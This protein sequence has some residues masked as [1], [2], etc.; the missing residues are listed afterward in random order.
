LGW[1]VNLDKDD[2]VG[3]EALRVKAELVKNNSNTKVLASFVLE[4][5]SSARHSDIII[6]GGAETGMVTSGS[7][8][9]TLET[10]IGMGYIE[11]KNSRPG[12]VIS[13]TVRKR[14]LPGK[15]SQ[16]PFYKRS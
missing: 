14:A 8:S 10:A 13:V 2:L 15:I 1:A 5:R 16:R 12:T 3:L 11:K 9:P 4:G 7:Y 6:A